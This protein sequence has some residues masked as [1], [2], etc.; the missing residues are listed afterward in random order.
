L[1]GGVQLVQ[2]R[3]PNVAG[4]WFFILFSSEEIRKE[5]YIAQFP[6]LAGSRG[7]LLL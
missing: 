1:L 2:I 7:R 3:V 4:K 5:Q 6:Y